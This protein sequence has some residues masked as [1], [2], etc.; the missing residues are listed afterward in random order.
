M[1]VYLSRRK[2]ILYLAVRS[3]DLQPVTISLPGVK[4][5]FILFP[6]TL[7]KSEVGLG[8]TLSHLVTTASLPLPHVLE[9]PSVSYSGG[10]KV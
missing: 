9:T 2:Y 3:L 10:A 6:W 5:R 7:P 8:S 1:K 4:P